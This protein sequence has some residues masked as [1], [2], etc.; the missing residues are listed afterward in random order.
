ML[1]SPLILTAPT[2]E[3]P[4]L[5]YISA[6]TQV[7]SAALVVEREEPGRSQKVQ[8]PVYFVSEVLSDSKTCYSQ[9]QKLVYAILMTKHK[10]RHYFNAHPITMVSKY[11]LG[12]VIQN[13]EAKGRIARWALELM[14]QNI[15][16]ALR[17][18]IKS[19]VLA[20]FVVEWTEIQTPLALIEHKTWIMY[21]D[22]SVMNE[23]AGVGLVFISPLGECMEYLVRLHF[24][25]SN[26]AAEYEALINSLQIAVEL[27]IKHLEIRGRLG[28]SRRSSYEGQE[29]RGPKDGDVLSSRTRSGGQVPRPRASSCAARLQ[30][31]SQRTHKDRIQSQPGASRGLRE[32]STCTLCASGGRKATQ[33]VGTQSHGD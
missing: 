28:A 26:N 4:M 9:I 24:P 14:E 29:L 1:K 31:S 11:P 12:E 6:T 15:T 32:R 2:L 10:L 8:R 5:L 13:P 33:G 18:A 3:E 7:V 30:Q 25:A 17:S 19:Q 16:Y 22:G 20:D 21:L 23:G 27:E